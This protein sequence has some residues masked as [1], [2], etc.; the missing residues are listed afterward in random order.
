MRALIWYIFHT[1]NTSSAFGGGSHARAFWV[2]F[3]GAVSLRALDQI[4]RKE[5]N[6]SHFG[7]SMA[8]NAAWV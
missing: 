2:T 7:V 4:R 5:K 6:G 1:I 8:K 3:F